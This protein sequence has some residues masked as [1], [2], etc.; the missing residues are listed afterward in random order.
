[1]GKKLITA[2]ELV[3]Q[4]LDEFDKKAIQEHEVEGSCLTGYLQVHTGYLHAQEAFKEVKT[5]EE[6]IADLKKTQDLVYKLRNEKYIIIALNW[7]IGYLEGKT[8]I[9]PIPRTCKDLYYF[10]L[11]GMK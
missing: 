7:V 5:E 8:E 2:K 10:P 6:A 4:H 1:M 3:K 11:A 9:P